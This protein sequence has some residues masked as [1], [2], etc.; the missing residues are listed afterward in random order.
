MQPS[1]D[2]ANVE[3]KGKEKFYSLYIHQKV[4]KQYKYEE[5]DALELSVDMIA[6]LNFTTDSYLLLRSIQQLTDDECYVVYTILNPTDLIDIRTN[7]AMFD[8]HISTLRKKILDRIYFNRSITSIIPLIDYL[9][10]ISILIPF[11]TIINGE[12]KTYEVEDVIK[13]GWVKVV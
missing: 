10:S 6:N 2:K 9:R 13:L 8:L 3:A 11:T 1:N 7:K 4:F 12:V 5:R